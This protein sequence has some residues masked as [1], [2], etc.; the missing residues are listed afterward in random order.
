LIGIGAALMKSSFQAIHLT[1]DFSFSRIFFFQLVWMVHIGMERGVATMWTSIKGFEI[2]G[3]G[4]S[5][6]LNLSLDS[7]Y[8][9]SYLR[10][11]YSSF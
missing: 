7:P 11:V 4:Q 9:D 5:I 8:W 2:D 3:L 10:R 6:A 1:E